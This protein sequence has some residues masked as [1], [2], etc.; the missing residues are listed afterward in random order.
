MNESLKFVLGDF[1]FEIKI[2]EISLGI[3]REVSP[4]NSQILKKRVVGT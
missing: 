2:G 3:F 1:T 4:P